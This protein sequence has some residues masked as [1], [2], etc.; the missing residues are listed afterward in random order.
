M[1]TMKRSMLATLALLGAVGCATQV[2]AP[3]HAQAPA[4]AAPQSGPSHAEVAATSLHTLAH[5][6]APNKTLGFQSKDEAASSTLA[7]PLP[8]FM[9][10]LDR[11]ANYRAGDDVRALFLD[12]G[13][14]LYPVPAGSEVRSSMIVRKVDGQWKATQF[15]RTNLAKAA[16]EGRARV[17][18]VRG[19][20]ESAM[21]L[22]EI[23]A[24]STR[25]LQ[26]EENGVPMLTALLVVP[27]ASLRAGETRPAGEVLA[28]LQ[29]LASRIDPS[30]PN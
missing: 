19:V 28:K 22:V 27:T 13:A 4:Q 18:S 25:F 24:L 23:P 2:D 21:T 15:G 16:H 1:K 29:P 7:A 17:S 12:E 9:V 10:R 20:G 3:P 6:V 11:L 8:M 5:L 30:L 14:M 26:H